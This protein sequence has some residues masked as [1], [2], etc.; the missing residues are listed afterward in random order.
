AGDF[1]G[2]GRSELAIYAKNKAGKSIIL[3][4]G[5]SSATGPWT[6]K[7]IP[8]ADALI[9]GRA[10][11]ADV[12]ND[13]KEDLITLQQDA[14][15]GLQMWVAVSSA[16][17]IGTAVAKWSDK[18]FE[19][20]RVNNPVAIDTDRNGYAELALFRQE[21]AAKSDNGASLHIFS[22]L[23]GTTT[24]AERWRS[25]GGFGAVKTFAVAEDLNGDDHTDLL[26]HYAD[27]GYRTITYAMLNSSTGFHRV[28]LVME[29]N[30]KIAELRVAE[31]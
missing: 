25:P 3:H 11:A 2:D 6:H 10:T 5:R 27:V 19:I 15:K 9:G 29:D 13:R 23:N 4:L 21:K 22:G 14:T 18:N 7:E 31:S 17:S 28:R 30:L 8:V 16:T 24:R 26:L 12:N 1:N 20:G